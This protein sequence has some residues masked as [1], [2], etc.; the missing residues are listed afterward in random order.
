MK[1]KRKKR[2]YN[3]LKFKVF[4]LSVCIL[5]PHYTHTDVLLSKRNTISSVDPFFSFN[6]KLN[7]SLYYLRQTS[8]TRPHN[9]ASYI[10][11][12]KGTKE[13]KS[14]IFCKIQNHSLLL[15]IQK[16]LHAQNQFTLYYSFLDE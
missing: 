8:E 13:L 11:M 16:E 1:I 15:R 7:K 4:K 3:T 10:Q 12:H 14:E 2:D 6:F 9:K 5:A